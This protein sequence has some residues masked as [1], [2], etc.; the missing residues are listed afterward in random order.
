LKLTVTGNSTKY[1]VFEGWTNLISVTISN[2]VTSIES[3]SFNGCTKLSSITI[4]NSVKSIY[5]F[6]LGNCTNLSSITV[7][8]GNK[9]YKSDDGVLLN[10]DGT[11][12]IQYACG[13]NVSSYTIPD[14]VKSIEEGAFYGSTR[15][16]SVTIGSSVSSI[17][18]YAFG[19]CTNLASINVNDNNKYFKSVDSVLFN[20]DGTK[21]I[22][23]ACGK[24]AYEYTIQDSVTSIEEGAFEGCK[25][26]MAVTV[27]NSVKTIGS[28]AF[29]GC[30]NL[31]SITIPK[32]TKSIGNYSFSFCTTL[33]SVIIGE[34]LKTIGSYAF[35]ECTNLASIDIPKSI[36][37]IGEYAFYDCNYL[38]NVSFSGS[39][40]SIGESA[41]ERCTRLQ[42]FLYHG[43]SDP[44]LL[45]NSSY[46]ICRYCSNLNYVCVP[47]AYNSSQFYGIRVSDS[48]SNEY[49][50]SC[51]IIPISE[52]DWGVDMD[53]L[54]G[55]LLG[56]VAFVIAI[57][58]ILFIV[59]RSRSHDADDHDR[60]G[61][62]LSV[63]MNNL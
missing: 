53:V 57:G 30:S 4:G 43:C 15:L 44:Q 42:T 12:L 61:N 11:K 33:R 39:I 26:L 51:I 54:A 7:D 13:K 45:Q 35:F 6:A 40:T 23:Y 24:S 47:Q 46:S 5:P 18:S 29:Y 58:S 31:A 41:F 49:M 8:D 62:E 36:K 10:K 63:A 17:N 28:S 59:T 37:T 22:Q 55:I 3:Y 20:K 25:N 16:N 32:S 19:N 1:G 60:S 52:F 9:D 21:L 27:G 48:C 50:G 2:S 34:S 38:R 14:S 56:C